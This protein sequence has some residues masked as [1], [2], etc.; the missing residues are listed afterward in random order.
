MSMYAQAHVKR[1]CM[2]TREHVYVNARVD[3]KN[4]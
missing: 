4:D 2:W 3:A 1:A